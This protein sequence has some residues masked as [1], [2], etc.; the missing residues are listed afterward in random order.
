MLSNSTTSQ[1]DSNKRNIIIYYSA[2]VVA[3]KDL[4][5]PQQLLVVATIV[6]VYL[7]CI[8]TNKID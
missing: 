5:S 7:G 2:C 4:L 6:P 1:M 8:V 3:I